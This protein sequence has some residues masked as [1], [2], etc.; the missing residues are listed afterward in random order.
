LLS[1]SE[2][3]LEALRP[4]GATVTWQ[5]D[6]SPVLRT[7]GTNVV[8]ARL[9]DHVATSVDSSGVVRHVD[10]RTGELRVASELEQ[11]IVAA[12]LSNGA[13]R[14]AYVTA[15]DPAS[16]ATAVVV[17][18]AAHREPLRIDLGHVDGVSVTLTD[19]GT[20]VAFTDVDY[21]TQLQRNRI[22]DVST[23]KVLH[24]LRGPFA[25]AP[26]GQTFIAP[27]GAGA[28][29]ALWRVREAEPYAVLP[30]SSANPCPATPLFTPDSKAVAICDPDDGDTVFDVASTRVL[31]PTVSSGGGPD[32][33]VIVSFS[34]DSTLFAFVS[35]SV[36]RV[37]ELASG[38]TVG[39]VPVGRE[40]G[41]GVANDGTVVV[42]SVEN[43]TL[44]DARSRTKLAVITA[45]N[46][47]VL[48]LPVAGYAQILLLGP[49]LGDST[50]A[51][52]MI[53]T[54]QWLGAACQIAGRNLTQSEWTQYLPDEPYGKT[55]PQW[56][57]AA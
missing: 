13:E 11:P 48:G 26:D 39:E 52:L 2:G 45:T 20:V 7:L 18:L 41:V 8:A 31:V 36:A 28:A 42:N 22:F 40:S 56:P 25:L 4:D 19:L 55:C 24:D 44:W 9:H 46:P 57:A 27:V 35:P 51:S 1:P 38:E 50:P 6:D 30:A 54:S 14:L 3:G 49:L 37:V 34:P 43:L 21:T 33:S 17:D 10:L 15:F 16:N 47:L 5:L 53:D 29:Y 32:A 12:A 23:G